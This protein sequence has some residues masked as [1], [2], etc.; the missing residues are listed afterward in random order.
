MR[1]PRA[2]STL[3]E[4]MLNPPPPRRTVGVRIGQA[5]RALPGAER[6]RRRWHRWQLRERLYQRYPNA[7][8]ILAMVISWFVIMI[9]V[10]IAYALYAQV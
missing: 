1:T 5:V 10:S 4:W 7:V 9:L 3:P 8:K 6:L 2:P